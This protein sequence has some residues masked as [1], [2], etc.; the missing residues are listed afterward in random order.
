MSFQKSVSALI[1]GALTCFGVIGVQG[2]FGVQ[3]V[4]AQQS[5][6][7]Q[8]ATTSVPPAAPAPA[9][10]VWKPCAEDRSVQCS[11]LQVPLDY[12]KPTGRT[13]GIAL[14]KVPARNKSRRIGSMLVNPGGP[15]SSGVGFALRAQRLFGSSIT[16]RFDVI[17]FDPRG[18]QRSA[19]IDCVTDARFDA[20][21]A[22]DPTPDDEAERQ[23]L[24]AVSKELADGCAKTVGV[25]VM[26]HL[27]TFDAAR[28][29]EQIRRSLGERQI[30]MMGFSYGTLLGATYAE[31]FPS[32]VRAFVLDGALDSA[33]SSDDRARIQ[34]KG[35]EEVLQAW[36]KG[37]SSR[38]SC[39]GTLRLD[40]LGGV[41]DLLAAVE[42]T[43]LKVGRRTVGPGEASLG[44]VRGLYSQRSG[45]PRLDS[46]IADALTGDGGAMLQLADDYSNR[47][48]RGKFDGL[49][50]ANAVINCIDVAA[51][52]DPAHYDELAAELAKISPR[53]GASIAYGG[54]TC[55]Y[56]PTPAM[57]AGWKTKAAGAA[58]ILVVGTTNDPATPYVWAEAMAA[59]LQS[60]VL[61]TNRGDN[62]TAYFTGGRCTR[63]TIERYLVELEVPP[64]GKTC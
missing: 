19:P 56:W 6:R 33:A 62:H 51:N 36:A 55:A 40:P 24:R 34:A 20:Y 3:R 15:G 17:G 14:A 9:K 50:E 2:T 23:Q 31:L 42:I 60:G 46:A 53:F 44:L 37:C 10:L 48:P 16:D 45:W 38:K 30:S 29:M 64:D 27:G 4:F 54:L 43:P 12:A 35:F 39:D 5:R 63:Q 7:V 32:R 58:P 59:Q 11:V 28:D 21:L 13:I 26:R 49:L 18:V 8:G 47:D 1:I 22:A 41:D 25:D 61:L 57:S 52:P